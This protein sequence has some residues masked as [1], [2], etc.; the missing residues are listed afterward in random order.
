MTGGERTIGRLSRE[1]GVKVPTIRF[2]EQIGLLPSPRRTEGEWRVYGDEARRRLGFIRHARDLGFS[3][4]DIRALL[5]LADHPDRPCAQA[6]VIAR[7]QLDAVE[8]KIV[9]L[10]ALRGELRRVAEACAGSTAAECRVIE[11]LAE[12][13]LC[14]D[15]HHVSGTRPSRRN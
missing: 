10:T 5:E 13:N 6:D 8:R 1:T 14:G 11:A 4:D 15:A 9:Q 12:R 7:T 2:Y 3:V